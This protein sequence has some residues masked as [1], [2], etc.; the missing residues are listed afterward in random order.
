MNEKFAMF[1]TPP[2]FA[3]SL[4]KGKRGVFQHPAK[5]DNIVNDITGGVSANGWGHPACSPEATKIAT[6]FPKTHPIR[7]KK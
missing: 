5:D 6:E 4:A 7:A 2:P 1:S 3:L